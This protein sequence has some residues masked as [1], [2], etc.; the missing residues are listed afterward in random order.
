MKWLTGLLLLIGCSMVTAQKR[1]L[2]LIA[3]QSNAVGQGT[4]S[5]SVLCSPGVAF[6]Y[7]SA[8]D[9]LV[10]LADPFGEQVGYFERA[11]TG[12]I[13][14]AFAQELCRLTGVGVVLLSA[15]RGGASCHQRAELGNYG[16]WAE[17]GKLPL[18]NEAVANT[19]RAMAKTGLTL[20]GIIWLQ[21]ERDANAIVDSLLTGDDYSAAL[22]SIIQRFRQAIGANVPV[23]IVQ[24]GYQAG[25][26]TAGSDAVRAAQ[27]AVAKRMAK[28]YV[29][30]RGTGEFGKRGWMKDYI[31]YNQTGLNEIGKQAARFISKHL[32]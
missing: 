26:T 29:A 9:S 25:R 19:K 2:F 21:G 3:G 31:H 18:L 28:T 13:A 20:G 1:H 24:T 11:A 7:L 30:Y 16:T 17:T 22:T 14:P 4:G 12:S 6:A 23:Y 5:E 8:T 32:N 27:L 15:G 10:A